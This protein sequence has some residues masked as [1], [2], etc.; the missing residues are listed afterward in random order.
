VAADGGVDLRR[1]AD[2]LGLF[3][4]QH[5]AVE[6]AGD[7]AEVVV[8]RGVPSI[9]ADGDAGDAGALEAGDGFRGQQRGGTGRNRGAET[10]AYAVLDQLEQ[11]GSLERIAAG[12][13]HDGIARIR[14]RYRGGGTLLG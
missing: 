3:E 5:G 12:E 11:I 6:G 2:A 8:R 14:A 4:G 10:E 13:D 1:E 9:H 7:L